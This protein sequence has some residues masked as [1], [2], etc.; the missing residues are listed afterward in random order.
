MN[1]TDTRA[2][3]TRYDLHIP[4]RLGCKLRIHG[5]GW[6]RSL[7][8]ALFSDSRRSSEKALDWG[9]CA[10]FMQSREYAKCVQTEDLPSSVTKKFVDFGAHRSCKMSLGIRGRTKS[11]QSCNVREV[12]DKRQS[13]WTR[14]AGSL[15]PPRYDALSSLRWRICRFSGML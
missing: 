9:D 11:R 7:S 6:L 13:R 5:T 12:R 2:S 15:S 8:L 14:R 4:P 1:S 3:R 10:R